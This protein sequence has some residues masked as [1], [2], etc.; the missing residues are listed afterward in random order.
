MGL[1]GIHTR[2]LWYQWTLAQCGNG[3]TVL[4]GSTINHPHSEIGSSC[5]VGYGVVLGWVRLGDNVL[6]SSQSSIIS[7]VNQHGT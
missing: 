2:R 6:V 7:G 5:F 1:G 3:L 4:W